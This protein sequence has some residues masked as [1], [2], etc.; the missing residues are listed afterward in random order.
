[1]KGRVVLW[2]AR[3]HDRVPVVVTGQWLARFG[4]LIGDRTAWR[5]DPYR[6]LFVLDIPWYW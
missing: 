1:M 4:H 3:K 6:D 2:G 5:W